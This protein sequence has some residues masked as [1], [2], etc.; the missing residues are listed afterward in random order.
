MNWAMVGV[1]VT[2]LLLVGA[3]T[4]RLRFA[5]R[6]RIGAPE[7]A[8]GAADAALPGFATSGAVVGADGGGALA[9]DVR[10]R[11]AVMRRRGRGIRVREVDWS[12]VRAGPEGIVVETGDRRL[13]AV[14]LTGVD[15][16]DI[17]RLSRG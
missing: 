16:L 9:V 6:G 17:R 3:G 7:E 14:S 11:V 4:W 5:G 2:V 1:V 12:A 8:A 15:A 10:G 13:G